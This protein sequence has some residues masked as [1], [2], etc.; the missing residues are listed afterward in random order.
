MTRESER[1]EEFYHTF[2]MPSFFGFILFIS[3][4][5]YFLYYPV[6]VGLLIHERNDAI[7]IEIAT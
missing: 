5:S 1:E 3:P 4:C 2:I 7:P 6:N